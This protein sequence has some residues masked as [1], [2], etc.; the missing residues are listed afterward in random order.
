VS[1]AVRPAS[2]WPH[3]MTE[4]RRLRDDLRS[5]ESDIVLGLVV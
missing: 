5:P 4:R 3:E 1:D 2:A